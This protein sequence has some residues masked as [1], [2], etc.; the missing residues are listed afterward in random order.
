MAKWEFIST[1]KGKGTWGFGL[2]KFTPRN[3]VRFAGRT[4]VKWVRKK[5][6]RKYYARKD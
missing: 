2:D 4:G 3:V 6:T 1:L 5:G